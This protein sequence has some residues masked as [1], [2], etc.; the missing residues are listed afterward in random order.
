MENSQDLYTIDSV[1]TKLR[2]YAVQ[3]VSGQVRLCSQLPTDLMIGELGFK[4]YACLLGVNITLPNNMKRD[5]PQV[6]ELEM[7]VNQLVGCS[8]AIQPKQPVLKQ[9]EKK[10][11]PTAFRFEQLP[12]DDF[13]GMI[14]RFK[15]GNQD[16][17]FHI[18]G[19]VN[20]TTH[21]FEAKM[22]SFYNGVPTVRYSHEVF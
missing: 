7:F 13:V 4:L 12:L 5:G 1:I 3:N 15:D 16:L 18:E 20:G 22:A 17:P 2:E 6:P 19:Y 14:S 21:H 10:P 11:N 9:Y 8:S